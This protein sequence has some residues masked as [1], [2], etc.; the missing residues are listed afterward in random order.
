MKLMVFFGNLLLY[1][2]VFESWL[3]E[4]AKAQCVQ[5]DVSIQYNISGSKKPT[6]RTND[7]TMESEPGCRG[8]SS[9]TTGVQ[10]H[11]GPGTV[12]Q[13][14]SVHHVQK[15]SRVNPT[16]VNSSTVQ[17]RSNVQV[18]VDNPVDRFPYK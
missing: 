6:Q 15:G 11:I 5:G 4:S 16:A 14:R 10:G 1:F 8:N 13:N 7:I 18:D 3:I 9:I 2:L 12:E 17:I